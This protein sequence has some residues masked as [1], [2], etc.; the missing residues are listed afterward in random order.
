M[1]SKDFV[2]ALLEKSEVATAKSND[3]E[4]LVIDWHFG[5]LGSV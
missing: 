2:D 1:A 4:R 3:S 5:L